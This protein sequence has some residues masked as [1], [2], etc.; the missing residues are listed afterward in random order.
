MVCTRHPKFNK[1]SIMKKTNV[2]FCIPDMI[3]GGVETVLITILEQL[4]QRPDLNIQIITHAKIREPLYANWFKQHPQIDVYVCYPWLRFFEDLKKH[5]SF[6]PFKQIRKLIF[7]LYKKY[8]RQ[9]IARVLRQKNFDIFIDFKSAEFY[10]ELK[11]VKGYKILWLHTALAYL[12][13]AGIMKKIKIYDKIVGITKDFCDEMKQRYPEYANNVVQIYNPIDLETLEL[14]L[15]T[16]EKP[17]YEI[18]YFCHVSRLDGRQKDIKTLLYAFDE[19]YRQNCCPQ[20]RLLIIGTGAQE[21]ELH[22]IAEKLPAGKNVVFLGGISN[23]YG[24]M[25]GALANVL[26]SN[27]E[28]FGMTLIESIALNRLCIASNCKFGPREILFDGRAG[29]L[30]G[31]GQTS[32]LAQHMTDVFRGKHDIDKMTKNAKLGLERFR[33]EHITDQVARLIFSVANLN[34]RGNL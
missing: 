26:S 20:V 18:P 33:A 23:P 10:K 12:E 5:C 16:A 24:Y 9:I 14:K 28:G 22:T 30:F 2:A 1:G 32:E 29:L 27:Y 8:R 25:R 4:L 17:K 34:N 21:K 7:S 11:L 3:L 13:S 31:V 15:A 6:F 19:F